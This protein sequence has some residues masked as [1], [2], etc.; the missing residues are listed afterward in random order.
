M[1]KKEIH[2]TFWFDFVQIYKLALGE[3]LFEGGLSRAEKK[4]IY[5]YIWK[6]RT[7]EAYKKLDRRVAKRIEL[8]GG[9]ER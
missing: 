7:R 3:I 2:T 5:S 8:V 4:I 9:I 1:N 6:K